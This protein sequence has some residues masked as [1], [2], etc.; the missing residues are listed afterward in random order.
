MILKTV[1]NLLAK[2]VIGRAFPVRR[3]STS[4]AVASCSYPRIPLAVGSFSASRPRLVSKLALDMSSI[5]PRSFVVAR[6]GGA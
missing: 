3:S 4:L 6:G 5:H 2:D 1:E